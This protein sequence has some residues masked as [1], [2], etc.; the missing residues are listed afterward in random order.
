MVIINSQPRGLLRYL[1]NST[2]QGNSA[3]QVLAPKDF[4]NNPHQMQARKQT[5]SKCP[6]LK[7]VYRKKQ[8]IDL[9]KPLMGSPITSYLSLLTAHF[10]PP[11]PG[12]PSF[13]HSPLANRQSPI[14]IRRSPAPIPLSPIANRQTRKRSYSL[15]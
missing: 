13:L 2:A 5:K 11:V 8:I 10:L 7:Y 4:S 1:E 6:V 12:P 14:A 9:M 3:K 15:P